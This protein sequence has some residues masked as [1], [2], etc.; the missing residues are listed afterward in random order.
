MRFNGFRK[1]DKTHCP[2]GDAVLNQ[3]HI[4]YCPQLKGEVQN[5][6]EFATAHGLPTTHRE[7]MQTLTKNSLSADLKN[8]KIKKLSLLEQTAAY[9]FK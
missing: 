3:H 9:H 4:L 2:C 6:L 8:S 7:L 1:K 5:I